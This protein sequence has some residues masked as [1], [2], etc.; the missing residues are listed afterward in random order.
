[1]NTIDQEQRDTLSRKKP[2]DDEISLIDLFAVLWHRKV[3]ILV[4]TLTAAVAV[5]VCAV[6]SLKLP[7][8]K[9][10]LPNE[11]TPKALMLIN[12]SSSS[13]GGG[14]ASMLASSGLG[15]LAGLAGVSTGSTSS[16]LAIYLV[17]TNTLLDS[18]V[19]EFDLITRWKIKKFYR[20][21]SRKT[22]KKKLIANYDEKSG[23]FS[24]SFTDIDPVFARGVVNY[25]VSYLQS[26]FDELG[27][28]KNKLEKEN[29]EKNIENTFKEIQKLEL[30]GH[31]LE[32]TISGRISSSIPSITLER[33]RIALELTAQQEVY[34]Q[35]KVQYELLKITMASEK[36]VFQVLEMA[37]VPDQKSGPSRGLLCIIVVFAAGFF[38]V[39]LAFVLNAIANIKNDPEAMAK[40]R[41]IKDS[42]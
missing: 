6:I 14:M 18:V 19:D 21:E 3:M 39:F 40:L 20:A 41:G 13:N 9:S 32:Q 25:C 4:I 28:D 42:A 10:F 2:D 1:M 37:E 35:L 16:D 38:S 8:E 27:I 24:I 34:S 33:N 23:V 36:P 17:G 5:V 15:G 12:N 11:Y 26:W 22:L 31:Q 29:L 30:E 7:A